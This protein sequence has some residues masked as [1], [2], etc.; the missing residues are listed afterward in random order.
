MAADPLTIIGDAFRELRQYSSGDW[1]AE[2]TVW[3]GRTNRSL[4]VDG[5]SAEEVL[6][7]LA[8]QVEEARA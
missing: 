1:H 5:T 8:R 2:A 7:E 4:F 3:H 6:R